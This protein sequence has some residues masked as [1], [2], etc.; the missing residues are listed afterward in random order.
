MRTPSFKV[1]H[2]IW[3]I[4]DIVDIIEDAENLWPDLEKDPKFQK[5]MKDVLAFRGVV[6]FLKSQQS[7]DV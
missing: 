7:M 6:G 4:K 3:A 2:F 5:L 1:D